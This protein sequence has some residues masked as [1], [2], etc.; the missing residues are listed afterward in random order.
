MRLWRAFVP[1]GATSGF[2]V[3][4]ATAAAH[5]QRAVILAEGLGRVGSR[6]NQDVVIAVTPRLAVIPHRIRMDGSEFRWGDLGR[7]P[8][9][10]QSGFRP[11]A[12]R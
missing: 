4:R 5:A 10:E 6:G 2:S 7:P 3:E 8:H 11:H 12:T 1:A 9:A